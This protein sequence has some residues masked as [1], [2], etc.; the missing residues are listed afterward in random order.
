[1]P[2][3]KSAPPK[4][5]YMTSPRRTAPAARLSS[6]HMTASPSRSVTLSCRCRP[7]QQFQ[8]PGGQT[9]VDDKKQEE[10]ETNAGLRRHTF[11]HEHV[12]SYNPGLSTEFGDEP[13]AFQGDYPE[14]GGK[15]NRAERPFVQWHR[16]PA[17]F[18]P[19][20]PDGGRKHDE[21]RGH[22]QIEEGVDKSWV[23]GAP[24]G[25]GVEPLNQCVGIEMGKKAEELGNPDSVQYIA[26]GRVRPAANDERR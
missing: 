22:H 25:K 11:S 16:T 19:P 21:E 7:N 3:P 15:E 2:P 24:G 13:A 20:E 1:M 8:Q 18:Q 17:P 10:H 14:R 26:G 4:T 9:Q 6:V 5:A 12:A 23:W